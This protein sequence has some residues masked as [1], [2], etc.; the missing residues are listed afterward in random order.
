MNS[1]SSNSNHA[2]RNLNETNQIL[3]FNSPAGV[4]GAGL[5]SNVLRPRL[6]KMRRQT[7]NNPRSTPVSGSRRVEEADPGLGFNPFR[8]SSESIFVD[9]SSVNFPTT[10]SF[11]AGS[12]NNNQ[13]PNLGV[14]DDLAK[15]KIDS[16]RSHSND[17]GGNAAFQ[18][19]AFENESKSSFSQPLADQL[20][21]EINKMKNLQDVNPFKSRFE[22][23]FGGKVEAELQH[24]M[25]K[26]NLGNH[27]NVGLD[28]ND[29]KG[30]VFGRSE[31]QSEEN[32]RADLISDRI[33]EQKVSSDRDGNLKNFV[34]GS[35]S[36]H[37]EESMKAADLISDR[38]RGLKV[39]GPG[40]DFVFGQNVE[41]KVYEAT[42]S[43]NFQAYGNS[44]FTSRHEKNAEFTF[45]SKLDNS[46]DPNVEFKTPDTK[47]GL[48]SSAKS[49]P[50]ARLKKKKGNVRKPVIGQR[51]PKQDFV[52]GQ[53]SHQVSESFEAYSPMDV[54]PYQH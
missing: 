1:S 19:K 48:F 11:G 15:L 29:L 9:S 54:S 47:G 33:R 46:W 53:S 31:Q 26:L 41:A 20:P 50:E 25:H 21:N 13:S 28:S 44:Y 7:S 18:F 32:V 30:F 37:S 6:M 42:T 45:S 8:T 17:I 3:G 52:F 2:F 49:I 36:K 51:E 12:S 38:M 23:T 5:G 10:F 24:E 4:A 35:K 22:S 43:S 14:V 40:E 39:G 27:G 16:N 34:F